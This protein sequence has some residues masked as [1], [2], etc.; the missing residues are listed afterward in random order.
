MF[1]LITCDDFVCRVAHIL[2]ANHLTDQEKLRCISLTYTEMAFPEVE[3][4][5]EQDVLLEKI[6]TNRHGQ[7]QPPVE[8]TVVALDDLK[9]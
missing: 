7:Y 3:R 8:G 9:D 1:K 5:P 4:T 2:T 6:Y